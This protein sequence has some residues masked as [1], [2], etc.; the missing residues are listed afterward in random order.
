MTG[1][2]LCACLC[3]GHRLAKEHDLSAWLFAM[4]VSFSSL[5]S[6]QG[7]LK[8][9]NLVLGAVTWSLCFCLFVGLRQGKRR[10]RKRHPAGI[11]QT[12]TFMLRICSYPDHGYERKGVEERTGVKKIRGRGKEEEE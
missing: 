10:M 8:A 3:L 2:C 4:G 9:P 5:T 1:L 6:K 7:P 12:C 11:V